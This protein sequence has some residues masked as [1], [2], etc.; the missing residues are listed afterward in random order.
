MFD[1]KVESGGNR[2]TVNN[3]QYRMLNNHFESAHSANFRFIS[4]YSSDDNSF[5]S[6][7]TGQSGDVLSK[8]YDDMLIPHRQ[9]KLISMQHISE[10][11]INLT[12][13][14]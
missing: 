11:Q 12:K 13:A 2:R 5:Y 7:D 10:S 8:H 14:I 1:R 6:V 4:D 3:A 9:Q